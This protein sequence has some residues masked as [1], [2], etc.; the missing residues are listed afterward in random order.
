LWAEAAPAL[1]DAG[2]AVATAMEVVVVLTVVTAGTP[3]LTVAPM[4]FPKTTV[5]VES[6]LP[7]PANKNTVG[8]K[9]CDLPG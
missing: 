8:H 5:F 4:V 2:E 6:V 3:A 7:E 9:L 1:V